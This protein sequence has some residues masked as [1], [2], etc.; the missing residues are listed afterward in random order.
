MD[1]P[2]IDVSVLP[3]LDTMTGM[4][5]SLTHSVNYDDTVVVI[6]VLVWDIINGG[7]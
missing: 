7:G 4:F 2:K 5:G 3:D 1:L 6:M